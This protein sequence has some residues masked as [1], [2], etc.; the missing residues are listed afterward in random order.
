[1]ST[2]K[3]VKKHYWACSECM[4]KAGGVYPEGHVCTMI[5]SKCGVCGKE[6]IM[7]PWVD[8]DWPDK[9]D[10]LTAKLTRD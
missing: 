5:K 2:L 6:G 8:Y 3:E 7:A 10:D 9:K 4:R 1:M